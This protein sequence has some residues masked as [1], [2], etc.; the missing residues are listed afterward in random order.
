MVSGLRV[1][2]YKYVLGRLFQ[3]NKGLIISCKYNKNNK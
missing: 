1:I 2:G 3:G